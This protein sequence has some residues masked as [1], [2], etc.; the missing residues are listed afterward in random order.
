MPVAKTPKPKAAPKV[1]A[2]A[3]PRA[4]RKTKAAKAE[5]PALNDIEHYRRV[6]EAAYYIAES[7]GFNPVRSLE[8][9]LEAEAQIRRENS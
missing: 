9:W 1:K 6:A 7:H 5:D 2:P 4:P 3:K 8:N